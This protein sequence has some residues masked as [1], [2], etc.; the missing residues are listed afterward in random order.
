MPIS[1]LDRG[2]GDTNTTPE[3]A[4]WRE[5]NV[6]P[7]SRGLVERDARVFQP[8]SLSTPCLSA[9]VRA[10][11]TWIEDADGRRYLDFHGNGVHHIGHAHPRLVAALKSQLDALTFAP[12]R[13]TCEPAIELAERLTTDGP[14]GPGSRILLA[15]GG[16]EAIE[17]ALKI[18]RLATGRHKTVSFWDAFHGAGFGAASVGGEALFRS[19]GIGPL[20]PGTEHVPPF[21]CRRCA[22]GFPMS[23]EPDIAVCRTACARV[24][25]HVLEREGDVAAVIAEP[26]RAVPHLPP[27]GFWAEVRA[28]CDATGALLI[29][30]EIPTGL[31]RTGVMWPHERYGVRPDIVVLGKALGGGVLP[32]AATIARAGLE[33]GADRA[34]GHYTHEKNPLLARAGLTTLDIIA[35]EDLVARAERSGR[36]AMERLN[37]LAARSRGRVDVRGVGLMIGVELS[38]VDG[39]PD[40]ETADAV[41]HACLAEGLSFKTTMGNVLTLTPPLTVSDAELDRALDILERAVRDRV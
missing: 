10:E 32:I 38:D 13:Y 34:I 33:V 40:R 31:G 17:I 8:Q 12:R 28:A 36:R 41:L 24:L 1:P 27:P 2:E 5:A 35:D 25:R 22:Y 16:S 19:A 3:R 7:R 15:P 9:V 39:E 11:G 14:L 6:G 37:V 20:L 30:D 4:R 29:F 21:A 18:A 23:G 26:V